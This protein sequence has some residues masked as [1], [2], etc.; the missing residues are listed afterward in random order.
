MIAVLDLER[1]LG[2][3][4]S[5]GGEVRRVLLWEGL[6]AQV[7][8]ILEQRLHLVARNLHAGGFGL[9][10]FV[11]L[12]LNEN[13]FAFGPLHSKPLGFKSGKSKQVL[14]TQVGGLLLKLIKEVGAE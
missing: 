10:P 1:V 12:V 13:L 2:L 4:Q 9:L 14:R 3:I 7:A 11:V 6:G 8:Q 5:V